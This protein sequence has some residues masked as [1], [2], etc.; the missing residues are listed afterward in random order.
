[1]KNSRISSSPADLESFSL[2][3][4]LQIFASETEARD[5]NSEDCERR[6]MSIGQWLL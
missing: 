5:K 1:M 3:M 4:A 6:G 2:L